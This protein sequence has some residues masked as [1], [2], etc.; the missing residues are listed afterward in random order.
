MTA[1]I[2]PVQNAGCGN[3][4]N[5]SIT[6]YTYT[7]PSQFVNGDVYYNSNGTVFLGDGTTLYGDTLSCL[8]GTI[9]GDGYFTQVGTCT[10]CT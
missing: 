6:L 3:S 7:T 10:N 8:Y 5:G 9:D 1:W 2:D 4:G